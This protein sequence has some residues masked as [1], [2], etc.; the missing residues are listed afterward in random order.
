MA[1]PAGTTY[2]GVSGVSAGDVVVEDCGLVGEAD[3]LD[4]TSD[5]GADG[6][7]DRPPVAAL[8]GEASSPRWPRTPASSTRTTSPTTARL[9]GERRR[10]RRSSRLTTPL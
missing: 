7:A 2:A 5:G 1:G 6:A 8:A 10:A 4:A 9:S 3:P